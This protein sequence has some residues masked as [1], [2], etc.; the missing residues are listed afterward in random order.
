MHNNGI[1][2]WPAHDFEGVLGNLDPVQGESVHCSLTRDE[3]LVEHAEGAAIA[4]RLVT[5][6]VIQLDVAQVKKFSMWS[7]RGEVLT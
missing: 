7:L 5:V 3:V 6:T 1:H 2:L 4:W